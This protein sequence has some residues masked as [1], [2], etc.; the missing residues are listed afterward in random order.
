[1]SFTRKID[2]FKHV[3][4]TRPH[5]CE[6]CFSRIHEAKT[7]CFAHIVDISWSKKHKFNPNNIALVCSILCHNSVDVICKWQRQILLDILEKW[8]KPDLLE[9][10]A[11][12]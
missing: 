4:E 2:L 1:M 6:V 8:E 11:K 9:L 5:H 7:W 12:N 10:Q 3:R